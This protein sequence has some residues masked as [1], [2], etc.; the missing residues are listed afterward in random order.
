MARAAVIL[1]VALSWAV[2]AEAR[3]RDRDRMGDGWERRHKVSKPQGDPD[4]DGLTNR[5]EFRRRTHPRRADTDRDGLRD[6]DELRFGWH[7]RRRDTDRDGIRDGDEGAGTVE[8]SDRKT[9]SIRL[10][11]GGLLAAAVGEDTEMVCPPTEYVTGEE[12]DEES[13]EEGDVEPEPGDDPAE[14][15]GGGGLLQKDP[16]YDD[17]AEDRPFEPFDDRC[18]DHFTPGA[19]VHS[20]SLRGGEFAALEAVE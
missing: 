19:R 11:S 5:F 14:P 18:L 20:A 10:A 1:L 2:P 7:P 6:A 4:K 15:S 3:D 16:D 12:G 17:S 9:I 8:A 13:D